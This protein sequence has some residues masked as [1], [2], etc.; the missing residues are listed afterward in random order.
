MYP[1]FNVQFPTSHTSSAKKTEIPPLRNDNNGARAIDE[2][3]PAGPQKSI[4]K[5][6][7]YGK[8]PAV[9]VFTRQ[10][11]SRGEFQSSADFLPNAVAGSWIT[12]NGPVSNISLTRI[13]ELKIEGVAI[14]EGKP[15]YSPVCVYFIYRIVTL[16]E[17]A[18]E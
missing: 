9:S 1:I 4:D 5:G 16:I 6:N 12:E 11:A 8:R 3:S 2:K 18:R 13:P 17:R 7:L 14:G 15:L 10:L